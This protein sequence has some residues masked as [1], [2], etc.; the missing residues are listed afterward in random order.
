MA[1]PIDLNADAGE[2]FGAWRLG[3]DDEL[4]PQLSSVNLA[5]GFH[6]GDALTMQR[7][8]ALALAHGVAVG[9]HPGFR[10]LA[11]FGRRDLAVSPSELYA[12]VLYQLGALSAF[13]R[14]QGG[15]LHHVKAHGALYLKMLDEPRIA[16]AVAGAVAAFDAALPLVTLAG[17]AGEAAA[18]AAARAGLR[19]VR[20][21][22]PDRAYLEG[23][24]LAPRTLAGAVIHDPAVIAARALTLAVEGTL[25]TLEGTPLTLTAQTLCLHGDTPHAAA[26]ARAVREA[27]SAAGVTIA[28]F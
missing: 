24:R 15:T 12:E 16:E 7:S 21:A 25:T 23:G 4:L 14:V 13:V 19:V 10:D 9:A 11:G 26:A 22:F 5:C 1:P 27:L 28:A 18:A 8:V 3:R 6:A 2:S 20:E 17:P